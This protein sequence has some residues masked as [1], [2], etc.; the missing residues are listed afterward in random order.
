MKKSVKPKSLLIFS[1]AKKIHCYESMY[2]HRKNENTCI[3]T[4]C[5]RHNTFAYLFACFF[6][7]SL[8]LEVRL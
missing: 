5:C 1:V 8:I 6:M 3:K 4:F 7:F 2:L